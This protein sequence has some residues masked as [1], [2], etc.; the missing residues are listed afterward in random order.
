MIKATEDFEKALKG[1]QFLKQDSTDL[2][3]Y[4]RNVNCH[5]A[6]KKCQDVILAARNLMSSE[7]HDTVKVPERQGAWRLPACENPFA[8]L[9]VVITLRSYCP[10]QSFPNFLASTFVPSPSARLLPGRIP[11]WEGEKRAP[12]VQSNGLPPQQLSGATSTALEGLVAGVPWGIA[13]D[14]WLGLQCSLCGDPAQVRQ[15]H[16]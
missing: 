16:L 6:S 12:S 14:N 11:E 15:A 8:I 5:F 4:A 2:L 1:M 9:L 13:V 7:M 10:Q 3:T